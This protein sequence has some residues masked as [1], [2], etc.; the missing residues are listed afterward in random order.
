MHISCAI[1]INQLFSL[2]NT[3]KEEIRDCERY[4]L[5]NTLELPCDKTKH[6][7]R[8]NLKVQKLSVKPYMPPYSTLTKLWPSTHTL[9]TFKFSL[10]NADHQQHTQH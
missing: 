10:P 5:H 7:A 4:T 6:L 2:H 8:L 3:L 9:Q 1:L